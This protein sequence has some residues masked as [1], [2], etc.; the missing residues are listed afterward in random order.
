MAR[1]FYTIFLPIL[2]L[3]LAVSAAPCD[4]THEITAVPDM[5]TQFYLDDSVQIV[6]NDDI[7]RYLTA[8][9]SVRAKHGANALTWNNTSAGLAQR[10]ANQ[11]KFEHSGGKLGPL[12]GTIYFRSDNMSIGLTDVIMLFQKTL[13]L[14]SVA[15]TILKRRSNP[16]PMKFVSVTFIVTVSSPLILW[17]RSTTPRTLSLL[18]S[19]KWFGKAPRR[20]DAPLRRA[21]TY[22]PVTYVVTWALKSC[23]LLLT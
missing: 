2:A 23:K 5:E 21:I 17:Q 16:G 9:N 8:H 12:G 1:F 11:C 3:A 6:V 7:Q 14:A 18:I 13:R 15:V 22:S 4:E 19:P 10:W 20:S